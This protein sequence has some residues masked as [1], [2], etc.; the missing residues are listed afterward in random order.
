MHRVGFI[1][2][3]TRGDERQGEV[4]TF[5]LILAYSTSTGYARNQKLRDESDAIPDDQL[6]SHK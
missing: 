4:H 2:E 1:V 5:K 6:P 3:T